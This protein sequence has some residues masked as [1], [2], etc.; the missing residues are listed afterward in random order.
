M[1]KSLKTHNRSAAQLVTNDMAGT[2]A[3]SP[4]FKPLDTGQ[5]TA[6][7][8]LSKPNEISRTS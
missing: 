1:H 8:I 2:I 3:K 4:K 5:V 7:N 6:K